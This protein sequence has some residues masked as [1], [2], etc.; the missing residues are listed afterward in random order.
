VILLLLGITFKNAYLVG[1]GWAAIEVVYSLLQGFGM[2]TLQQKTDA[3][4]MEAKAL[5]KAIGMEE[6][7]KP[8]APFWGI[9]ERVGANA[10][11]ISLGLV[12]VISPWL[13][14]ATIPLHSAVN[15][16]FTQTIKRSLALTEIAFTLFG[17]LLFTACVLALRP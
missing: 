6:A 17:T 3:K 7:L 16:L 9:L 8:S 1:L 2:A 4:A 13:A 5:M 10:L 15:Y 11:H 14:I 12:L